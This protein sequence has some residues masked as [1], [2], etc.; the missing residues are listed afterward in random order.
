MAGPQRLN[1]HE[2]KSFLSVRGGSQNGDR[3]WYQIIDL[4][5]YGGNAETYYAMCTEPRSRKGEFYAIKFFT[6]RDTPGRRNAFLQEYQ[7]L[8]SFRHMYILRVEY[9]GRY[10]KVAEYPFIV[11]EYLPET[12]RNV[13]E[14]EDSTTK[15][16][17]YALQL[18]VALNYLHGLEKP[19]IHRDI[20]PSNIFRKGSDCVLGDFGLAK[21]Y[22]DV[23]MREED[24]EDDTRRLKLSHG[25]GM[26]RNYRSPDHVRYYNN[27]EI[28]TPAADVFQLGLV[29]AEAFTGRNLLPPPPGNDLSVWV[30]C[31]KLPYIDDPVGGLIHALLCDMLETDPAERIV[32]SALVDKWE[33]V[34][35]ESVR[36]DLDDEPTAEEEQKE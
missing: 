35:K 3:I 9:L 19:V 8:Q 12:F 4:A 24:W 10:I 16:T 27:Q 22:D 31:D 5:G 36:A 21:Q 15:K 20:K 6:N 23:P 17:I 11:S 34:M 30:D 14:G 32:T 28:I 13:I 2:K 18:C 29:L 25:T 26:P 33:T 1:L 7:F